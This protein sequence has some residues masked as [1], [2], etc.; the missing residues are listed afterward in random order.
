MSVAIV[1]KSDGGDDPRDALRAAILKSKQVEDR[2]EARRQ[3]AARSRAMV[4]AAQMRLDAAGEALEAARTGHA[5]TLA[6]AAATGVTPKVDGMLKAARAALGDAEDQAQ[7]AGLAVEQVEAGRVEI[8]RECALRQNDI[9]IEVASV[10]RPTLE[11]LMAQF[12]RKK[13]ELLGLMQTIFELSDP[14]SAPFG[15]G[16][17]S[18]IA[19]E[20]RL[21]PFIEL[22]DRVLKLTVEGSP[23]E[24]R[25]MRDGVAPWIRWRESLQ[26]YSDALPPDGKS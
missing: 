11:D 3:V 21:R 13:I 4:T 14:Q 12:Q 15:D 16:A 22:R 20:Q 6:E 17:R 8:E 9:L 19:H 2:L 23:D 25:A 18:F 7:A 10:L 1:R 26:R 5:Q 24:R